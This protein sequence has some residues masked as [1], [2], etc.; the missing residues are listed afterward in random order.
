[1]MKEL[2]TFSHAFMVEL[3]DCPKKNAFPSIKGKPAMCRFGGGY[4]SFDDKGNMD[5]CHFYVQDYQER[6]I[7]IN[8]LSNTMG[9]VIHTHM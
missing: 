1:M 5:G 4:Y 7:S 3:V 2:D 8:R 6:D 9:R